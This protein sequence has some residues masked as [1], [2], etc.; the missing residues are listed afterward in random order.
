MIPGEILLAKTAIIINEGK[1]AISV[2]VKNE[3]TRAVQIG[4]HYHFFE[5]N[6]RLTFDRTKTY[7]YRLDIPAGTA[8]R[9]EPNETV[10]V[11]LIEISG[12][13]KVCGANGFVQGYLAEN[14]KVA[15]AHIKNFK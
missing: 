4:S 12:R 3:G 14:K 2:E 15:L 1:Q 13:R 5:A 8:V 9:I 7:G 10:T 6:K 11:N